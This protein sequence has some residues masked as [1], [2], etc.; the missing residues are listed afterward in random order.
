MQN[1]LG[2]YKLY[3]QLYIRYNTAT[4]IH[5]LYIV[6]AVLSHMPRENK[7]II[8]RCHAVTAS[9]FTDRHARTF[10]PIKKLEKWTLTLDI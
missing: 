10:R 9:R 1:L 5:V 6:H 8:A 7:T 3:S 4:R 2:L